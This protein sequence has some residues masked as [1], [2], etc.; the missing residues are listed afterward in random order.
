LTA[1]EA[2]GTELGERYV[3][4]PMQMEDLAEI[5][6]IEQATFPHPWPRESFVY[7]IEKNPFSYP[8]VARAKETERAEIAGY[9][10]KWV[11]FDLM[12][13]QNIAVHPE[14]QRQGLGRYLLEEALVR[15]KR[16]GA[17]SVLLEVRESNLAAQR[18]YD[19]MGFR[20]VG[21]RKRYYS[22]PREDALIY[23]KDFDKK[24]PF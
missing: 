6:A 5:L 9:C 12:H 21:K 17:K 10:V 1:V 7:E 11:V 13:I 20:K 19:S 22:H 23:Q 3:I 24:D 8:T 18:L 15:G 4:E 16:L 2:M 14:H